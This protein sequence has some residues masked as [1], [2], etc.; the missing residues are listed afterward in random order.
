MMKGFKLFK[1]RLLVEVKRKEKTDEGIHLTRDSVERAMREATSGNVVLTGPDVEVAKKGD[2]V[3]YKQYVGN[4]L[5]HNA[6][7]KANHYI[8]VA[9]DDLLAITPPETEVLS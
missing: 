5:V 8:V 4:E 3:C 7:P 9:E 6:L 2:I 1:N